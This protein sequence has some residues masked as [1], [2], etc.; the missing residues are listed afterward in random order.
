M[1]KTT[2]DDTGIKIEQN[3]NLKVDYLSLL[4][5]ADP[6]RLPTGAFVQIIS[7]GGHFRSV[8]KRRCSNLKY[9][10]V[11]GIKQFRRNMSYYIPGELCQDVDI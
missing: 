4:Y 2:T 1:I 3:T 8:Q 7:L 5:K 6:V 10:Q 11:S 9:F